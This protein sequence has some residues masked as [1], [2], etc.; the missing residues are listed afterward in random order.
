MSESPDNHRQKWVLNG[1][2]IHWGPLADE[3][4]GVARLTGLGQAC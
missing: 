3:S 1:R 2:P 4:L